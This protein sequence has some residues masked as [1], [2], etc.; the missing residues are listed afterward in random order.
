MKGKKG[1]GKIVLLLGGK[2]RREGDKMKR[3][4]GIKGYMR[5][6]KGSARRKLREK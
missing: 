4:G 2:G 3:K 1:E 6:R 5:G